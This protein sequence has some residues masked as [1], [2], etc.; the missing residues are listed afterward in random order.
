MCHEKL[1]RSDAT[2]QTDAEIIGAPAVVPANNNRWR[3]DNDEEDS[4]VD[5]SETDED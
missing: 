3:G 5:D 2:S 1:Y 4:D